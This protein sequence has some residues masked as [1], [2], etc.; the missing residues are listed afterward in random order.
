MKEKNVECRIANVGW[1]D[2]LT[3]SCGWR[4]MSRGAGEWGSGG[5]EERERKR[6]RIADFGLE[7]KRCRIANCEL[8]KNVSIR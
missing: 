3:T 5:A 8:R 2:K 4:G 7:G 6:L 1:F